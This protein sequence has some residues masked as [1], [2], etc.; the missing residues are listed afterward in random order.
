MVIETGAL[1]R[2]AAFAAETLP[3]RRLAII[4]DRN[5]ARVIDH[6]LKA[7]VLVVPP[8]EGSK[9]RR[10]WSDLTDQLLDL[11]FGRDAGLVAV[12]G[13]V[14]GDLTGFVAATFHRGIPYLQVPTSLLAMVD[15]VRVEA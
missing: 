4:T 12:G 1:G 3:G 9:T 15:A 10:R 13:G 7:P 8:G 14:V 11:G 5:V 2:L 6:D